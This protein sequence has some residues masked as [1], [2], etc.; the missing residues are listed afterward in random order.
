MQNA[1]GIR[2]GI[3]SLIILIVSFFLKGYAQDNT[4]HFET[5]NVENGLSQNTVY[6]IIQDHKG[7]LWIGTDDG[8]NRYDGYNFTVFTNRI[9]EKGTLANSRVI[10][11]LEDSSKRL[12]VGT[13]G[14]GLNLYHWETNSFTAYRHSDTDTLS[15]SNDRVMALCEDITGSIWVG[16]AD[17]GLNLF[18]PESEEFKVYM[19][20]PLTPNVLPSNVIR[21]LYID[22]QNVLWVGTD[23][24]VATYNRET[25]SFTPFKIDLPKEAGDVKIVRRFLEDKSGLI[26]MATDEQGLICYDIKSQK[27]SL[28]QHNPRSSNSLPSNTVHDLF[29]DDEGNIWVA[30]YGGLSKLNLQT[31]S[32]S[33]YYHSIIDP[34]SLASNLLRFIFEDSTGVFWVGTYDNG[35]SRSNIKHKKF[36]VFRNFPG[37]NFFLGAS[38]TIRAMHQDENGFLWLGSYGQGLAKYSIEK[39]DFEYFKSKANTS[40]SLSSNYINSIDQDSKGNLFIATNDGLVK[41]NS[42]NKLFKQ[43]KHNPNNASSLPDRR[44]RYVYVDSNDDVWT[45]NL[46]YGL[47]KLSADDNSFKTYRYR[48]NDSTTITQ[49]RLTV[50]FEDSKG[51]FWVGT[52]NEGLNLFDREKEE[53]VK[54]YRKN[55]NDSLSIA[56]NRILSFYEDTKGR[57]WVGTAE[58][59]SLFDYEKEA[60]KNFTTQHG[61]PNN[62]IYGILEDE[63]GNLWMSTNGGISR[64]EILAN[65]EF[66]FKNFDKHDGF[67]SNEFSEGS[68][69]KLEN[70]LLAF[71][72]IN[73]FIIF[74]PLII[75]EN[76]TKA[77]P[78]IYE[79]RISEK[80]GNDTQ[81]AETVINLLET[82]SLTF[83]Y[84]QNNIS[85]YVTILHYI[86]PQ[87]NRYKYKLEGFDKSW[88]YPK[89]LFRFVKYTNLK[90]GTYT[91]KILAQ[92]S[93]GIWNTQEDSFTF[94]IKPPFWQSWFFYIAL[95]VLAVLLV[96]GIVVYRDTRLM[97]A[98]EDLERMVA[99]RTKELSSQS[100]ELRMQSE[101]LHR[102]ND[103]INAKS[104]EL[105]E[106]NKALHEKNKEITIQRNELE[107]QKNSLANLAWELQDKNEEITAQRNEIERQKIEITDSIMYAQRIQQAVLPTQEQIRELF[108]EFFIFNKP[109]SIVSGDFYWATR[110]GKYRIVAVVDCTGHGVPGG[111]MSMLGVLM[112]NEVI[113]LR[114]TV[115]PAKV[116]NQLREGI[117]AVLHQKGESEDATDGMDLSLCVIDD[118]ENT[119]TYS[120]ANSTAIIFSPTKKMNEAI[121]ELRSD[122]MPIAHHLIMDPF[123]NQT[124]KLNQGDVV[125]LYTDGIM[126]QFGGPKNK[127]FQPNNFRLFVLE[128][129]DL[130]MIEQGVALEKVFNEWKGNT[131]QVDDVLVMGLKV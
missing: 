71:G 58:G 57:L 78:Y 15:L 8:L 82:D 75:K 131:F 122:R 65:N 88:I 93:D 46:N 103:E 26:W 24:G 92:N 56:S 83:R 87:K 33:N 31:N 43:F 91:F 64:L 125:Y 50:V 4:I 29:L 62:V 115:N 11:L 106:Q 16:T 52:S 72:S 69:C 45:A 42:K 6:T 68:S 81:N 109:K 128:H 90:P 79:A 59:L 127:K 116:L 2:K 117:I 35:L 9:G 119:L 7:F 98:K 60:F 55:D 28:F 3:A 80:E 18:N 96:Y 49:D 85:F 54:V 27:F 21:S 51:N 84:T 23:N 130:S 77:L 124:V 120:G 12:W 105:E 66:K 25:D 108:P 36:S 10:S 126:D 61:L 95:F 114:G 123:T 89:E 48:L 40:N 30:T 20:T 99:L 113:S 17:G 101:N 41:F 70:G 44:I 100:E 34:N 73:S 32:F 86:A 76:E 107:E 121:N 112:F 67:P 47:S 39:N 19:N 74:D 63:L 22:S 38:S 110:I 14:G 13:I 5:V 97:H 104:K 129:K 94:T 118:D 1:I 37:S 102:A 111:F 53:V